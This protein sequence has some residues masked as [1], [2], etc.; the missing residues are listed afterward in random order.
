MTNTKAPKNVKPQT[1]VAAA[2]PKKAS[3]PKTVVE[4]TPKVVEPPKEENVVLENVPQ[5]ESS[6]SE[7]FA[8]VMVLMGEL[9]S[10]LVNTKL[11]M[12]A[13]E[14]QV[15]KEMKVLDKFNQK[16]NKNKGTRAPSGFVKPTKISDELAVFLKKEKGSMM[17]RTEVTKE[18]TAYIREKSLQDKANGRKILPDA[19]LKKLLNLSASDELTYFNLQKYMSPHFEKS[20]K[21]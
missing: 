3:S 7:S 11:A 9:N 10:A 21:A 12:K 18:M 4:K 8:N 19:S 16:K 5:A 6:V 17:A 15:S 2:K 14:K 1:D 20:V 13:L